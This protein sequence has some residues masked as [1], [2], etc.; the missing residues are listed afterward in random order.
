MPRLLRTPTNQ[1]QSDCLGTLS[2]VW[3]MGRKWGRMSPVGRPTAGHKILVV[4]IKTWSKKKKDMR[5]KKTCFIYVACGE[6]QKVSSLLSC[7]L[8]LV[9]W[10]SQMKQT[11]SNV[12]AREEKHFGAFRH[13]IPLEKTAFFPPHMKCYIWNKPEQMR[14]TLQWRSQ[15]RSQENLVYALCLW[16]SQ[17][18]QWV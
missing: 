13:A 5:T 4:L 16:L 7:R 14:P 3:V 11:V 15:Q 2:F 1:E 18:L 10:T 9:A 8:S 6:K 17:R 12:I